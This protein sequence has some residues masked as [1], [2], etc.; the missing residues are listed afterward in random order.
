MRDMGIKRLSV[1]LS[2]PTLHSS[3]L[4]RKELTVGEGLLKDFP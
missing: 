1:A 3:S 2:I 4:V